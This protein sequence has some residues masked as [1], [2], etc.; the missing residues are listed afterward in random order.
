MNFLVVLFL[1]PGISKEN[2]I[3][4][5]KKSGEKLQTK[6]ARVAALFPS[7]IEENFAPQMFLFNFF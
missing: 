5:M 6:V 4:C 3:Y 1:F 2:E 7:S